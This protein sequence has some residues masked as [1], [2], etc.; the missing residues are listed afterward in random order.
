M[1][2]GY[3][4]AYDG[5]FFN[6]QHRWLKIGKNEEDQMIEHMRK[7][8]KLNQSN[9]LGINSSGIESVKNYT[10]NNSAEKIVKAFL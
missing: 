8:H 3:E 1:Q 4:S 7:I 5:K 6:G 2:S 9:N 10:W